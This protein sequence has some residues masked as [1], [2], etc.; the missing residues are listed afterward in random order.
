MCW[1]L[2]PAV[3]EM[4]LALTVV[5]R[6]RWSK[7]I[8]VEIQQQAQ[9]LCLQHCLPKFTGRTILG[10]LLSHCARCNRT[11]AKAGMAITGV[12][13]S[14][15]LKAVSPTASVAAFLLF[16]RLGTVVPSF[17]FCDFSSSLSTGY[18]SIPCRI[19]S[20]RIKK[21]LS[22]PAEAT[23]AKGTSR[24]RTVL[25]PGETCFNRGTIAL[26]PRATEQDAETA[27]K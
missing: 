9:S 25:A 12:E 11:K 6:W 14:T 22:A 5:Q 20:L 4:L 17:S 19:S 18:T 27:R 16:P 21:T 15:L 2:Q 10:L 23:A 7:S 24:V 13:F 1:L 3:E 26:S 8:L